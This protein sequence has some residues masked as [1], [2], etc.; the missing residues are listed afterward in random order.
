MGSPQPENVFDRLARDKEHLPELFKSSLEDIYE[1]DATEIQEFLLNLIKD[2]DDAL[3]TTLNSVAQ[4]LWQ[5][6]CVKFPQY[7]NKTLFQR[8]KCKLIAY[9]IYVI[10]FALANELED[11][12][13]KR[14]TKDS[15]QN[16][17]QSEESF[18][19]DANVDLFE[20]CTEL[21]DLVE[22]LTTEVKGLTTEVNGLK[23][24]LADAPH[25]LQDNEPNASNVDTT[26]P[27]DLPP[28]ERTA[29][30]RAAEQERTA[31][32]RAA[33]PTP[34]HSPPEENDS[35]PEENGNNE[36]GGA[37]DPGLPLDT[38]PAN[39]A[40]NPS[41]E[42][43]APD[44]SSTPSDTN[45]VRQPR[46]TDHFT[47]PT[48]QR[49]R[50]RQGRT[51]A[52]STRQPVSGSSTTLQTIQGVVPMILPK[53]VYVGRLAESVTVESLRKHLAEVGINNITDVIDLKCRIAGQS[54]FCIIA[55]GEPA[56]EAIY[57]PSIW[58]VGTKIR[59]YEEKK[60]NNP[61]AQRHSSNRSNNPPN[62]RPGNNATN[63]HHRRARNQN[64]ASTRHMDRPQMTKNTPTTQVPV[65]NNSVPP[66]IAP[67]I[68]APAISN[69][70]PAMASQMVPRSVS[71]VSTYPFYPFYQ[72]ANRFS[73]LGD[74]HFA[75]WIPVR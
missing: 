4:S 49:V 32:N 18:L 62:Y 48:N 41:V 52:G 24:R 28:Q 75:T 10:G 7:S 72:T 50:A 9:D 21:R 6:L 14:I 40:V 71:P 35:P 65:Q 29:G 61:P 53:S 69:P 56:E 51:F 11:V 73:P 66:L 63:M 8:R 42:I 36:L 5:D 68:T 44:Q 64:G 39:Q 17:G 60:R 46:P 12:R 19:A 26:R 67:Q 70:P 33:E 30:N 27:E 58:P 2:N 23:S 15:R 31:G 54:S 25:A 57:N 37:R 20:I 47:L 45:T 3:A 1:H 55:D 34:P 59:P 16:A 74:A 43:E 13:L 22:K 38:P